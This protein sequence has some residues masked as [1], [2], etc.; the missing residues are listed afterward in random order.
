[1]ALALCGRVAASDPATAFD[2]LAPGDWM[3]YTVAAPDDAPY[4]CCLEWHGAP[5]D[6]ACA[7]NGRHWNFSTTHERSAS[8][9][10]VLVERVAAGA[11][12]VRALD[13]QCPL[14]TGGERVRAVG[15]MNPDDSVRWLARLAP[16]LPEREHD[17]AVAALALHAGSAATDALSAMARTPGQI[18]REQAIFWLGQTRGEAGA[19][20]LVGIIPNESDARLREHS[21]FS[22]SQSDSD[23]GR[24]ALRGFARAPNPLAVRSKA[25]FW[26]AQ[27][28]DAEVETLIGAVLR[29]PGLNHRLRDEAVF[30]LAQLPGGRA[31]PALRAV[32]DGHHDRATRKQALFWL[33]Q[34]DDDEALRT[35]ESLIERPAR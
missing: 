10:R 27:Q 31:T 35:L 26:L 32:L 25:L 18:L 28:G 22:L 34:R 20:V 9:L 19:Q 15:A 4:V 6:R 16:R 21:I 29:E 33:A 23:Y 12:R 1:L 30:A 13:A 3:S 2:T 5:R 8:A 11:V 14:D 7:L 24:R 17:S